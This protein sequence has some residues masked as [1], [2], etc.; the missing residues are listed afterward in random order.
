MFALELPEEAVAFSVP[1]W[2][3][4]PVLL[5]D[6]VTALIDSDLFDPDPA[7]LAHLRSASN[8]GWLV[9]VAGTSSPPQFV[10]VIDVGKASIKVVSQRP[11]LGFRVTREETFVCLLF[12]D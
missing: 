1:G 10:S 11:C 6:Q 4:G 2:C 12:E 7:L 9:L 3:L 5:S 8:A